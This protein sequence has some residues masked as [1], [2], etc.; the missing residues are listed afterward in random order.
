MQSSQSTLVSIVA[1]YDP[2]LQRYA[3]RLI[4]NETITAIIVQ[5]VLEAQYEVNKLVPVKHLR[6]RLK[7]QVLNRC[8]T[9][10]QAQ[11]FDRTK[12]KFS[13]SEMIKPTAD[14]ENN[15]LLN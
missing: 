13:F 8:Y 1:Y 7:T 5:D 4:K 6:Q 10:L 9:W 11:I 3:R 15:P 14:N 12:P 2:L